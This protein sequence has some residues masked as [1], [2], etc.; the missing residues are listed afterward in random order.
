M[1]EKGIKG[2]MEEFPS[3]NHLHELMILKFFLK[4]DKSNEK[5]QNI[6]FT[7]S[8]LG[9]FLGKFILLANHINLHTCTSQYRTGNRSF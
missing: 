1:Q 2:T 5:I 6:I 3:P 8:F 4:S 7:H 9:F